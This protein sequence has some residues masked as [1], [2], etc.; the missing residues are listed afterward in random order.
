MRH[1]SVEQND[2]R[3][4][5]VG[6]SALR[7][8]HHGDITVIARPPSSASVSRRSVSG[9]SSLDERDVTLLG[10]SDHSCALRSW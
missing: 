8:A 9:E 6:P 2:V 4:D 5:L 1:D 10:F 3:R 7:A